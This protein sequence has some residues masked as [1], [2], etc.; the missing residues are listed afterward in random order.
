MFCAKHL[1]EAGQSKVLSTTAALYK[2]NT[3][4]KHVSLC[5]HNVETRPEMRAQASNTS[6]NAFFVISLKESVNANVQM[7]KKD[8]AGCV[9]QWSYLIC[10][11]SLKTHRN[12]GCV[13]SDS[14]HLVL[15]FL[16]HKLYS[17]FWSKSEN[18]HLPGFSSQRVSQDI[19]ELMYK[20]ILEK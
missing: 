2:C 19:N 17:V 11:C 14:Y 4:A 16:L 20:L 5:I 3:L 15:C 10:E 9:F 12:K 8:M 6:H 1:C 18:H 7:L 13:F